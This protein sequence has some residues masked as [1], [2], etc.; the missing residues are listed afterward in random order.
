MKTDVMKFLDFKRVRTIITKENC[1]INEW[2]YCNRMPFILL[3]EEENYSLFCVLVRN[4][5]N[6]AFSAT[7]KPAKLYEKLNEKIHNAYQVY[8]SITNEMTRERWFIGRD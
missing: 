6:I 7:G 8:V 1:D 4:N 5:I 3:K 2:I